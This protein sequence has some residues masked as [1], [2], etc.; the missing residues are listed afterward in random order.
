M[1]A[2][3]ID[4]LINGYVRKR[5]SLLDGNAIIPTDI[6]MLCLSFYKQPLKFII[7]ARMDDKISIFHE[8]TKFMST[9]TNIPMFVPGPTC[10]IPNIHQFLQDTCIEINESYSYDFVVII[11]FN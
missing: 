11:E 7:S 1:A 10:Y 9:I 4:S 3:R 6:I 5:Q 2:H 8:D